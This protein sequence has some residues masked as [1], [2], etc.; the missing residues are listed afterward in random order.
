M[1]YI[2]FTGIIRFYF[3]IRKTDW[4]VHK[5]ISSEKN[6]CPIC[7]TFLSHW[8]IASFFPV[9]N[10]IRREYLKL[11]YLFNCDISF[12]VSN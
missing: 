8:I 11:W 10:R 2:Y 3:A 6:V 1:T 4:G 7:Q 12:K 5:H 9:F